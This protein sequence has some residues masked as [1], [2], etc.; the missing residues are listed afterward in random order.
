MICK[1]MLL[2]FAALSLAHGA[3]SISAVANSDASVVVTGSEESASEDLET[4]LGEYAGRLE[5]LVQVGG[6]LTQEEAADW[7]VRFE[8]AVQHSDNPLFKQAGLV[9]VMSIYN[10]F[11]NW[12][13]AES[14][15]IAAISQ[16]TSDEVLFVRLG[17]LFAIQSASQQT[18]RSIELDSKRWD[19]FAK[20]DGMF[21]KVEQATAYK[22]MDREALSLYRWALEERIKHQLENNQLRSSAEL[23]SKFERIAGKA[24]NAGVLSVSTHAVH[25]Y[26]GLAARKMLVAGAADRAAGVVAG[27]VEYPF[28]MTLLDNVLSGQGSVDFATL[29]EFIELVD[30]EKF[31]AE[32]RLLSSYLFA[33]AAMESLIEINDGVLLQ[34]DVDNQNADIWFAF[35]NLEGDV[36]VLLSS[37]PSIY[38][39][40]P[41]S[42]NRLSYAG[43]GLLKHATEMLVDYL[44]LDG[45]DEI[46]DQF[47]E[48][49]N[50]KFSE[51]KH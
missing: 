4:L 6:D 15:C 2:T 26:R 13:A 22:N 3:L 20:L 8:L 25:H 21:D 33:K 31:P 51:F 38:E 5:Y 27:T 17:D 19:T 34:G 45:Q 46:A 10:Q 16:A 11:E 42:A 7:V 43:R 24:K 50:Q 36:A 37:Q 18:H 39:R 35:N 12:S 14:T 28:D 41:L 23:L 44:L 32:E 30:T 47:I 29:V 40:T 9:S 1:N 48:M 49:G